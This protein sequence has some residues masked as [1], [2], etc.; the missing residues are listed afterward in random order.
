VA[1]YRSDQFIHELVRKPARLN[2]LRYMSI[3]MEN[4]KM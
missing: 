3:D 4:W 1:G 2:H